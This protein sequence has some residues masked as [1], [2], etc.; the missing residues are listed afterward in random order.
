MAPAELEGVAVS[1]PDVADAG[2]IGLPDERSGEL[3][4]AYVVLKEGKNTSAKDIMKYMN[5]MELYPS[6]KV[7][8]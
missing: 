6:C 1:H 7:N 3:P 8:F 4:R 2:V 5:G